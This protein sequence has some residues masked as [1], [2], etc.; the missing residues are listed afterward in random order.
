MDNGVM[1]SNISSATIMI[2]LNSSELTGLRQRVLHRLEKC[3]HLLTPKEFAFLM[4]MYEVLASAKGLTE[5]QLKWLLDILERTETKRLKR[6][7]K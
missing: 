5:R 7:A 4:S 2:T 6:I 3:R 1:A